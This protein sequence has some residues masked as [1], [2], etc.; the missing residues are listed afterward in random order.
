M[1]WIGLAMGLVA[2][3]IVSLAVY[4]IGSEEEEPSYRPP[5]PA[6]TEKEREN[7]RQIKRFLT[8]D[9]RDLPNNNEYGGKT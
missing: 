6:E 5:P 8:Y 1:Y 2:G 9:G 3:L 4:H 7:R